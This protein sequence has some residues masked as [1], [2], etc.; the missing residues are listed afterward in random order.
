MPQVLEFPDFSPSGTSVHFITYRK[1]KIRAVRKKKSGRL[2]TLF[3]IHC[4]RVYIDRAVAILPVHPRSAVFRRGATVFFLPSASGQLEEHKTRTQWP[5]A[6]TN[7]PAT[8][9]HSLHCT[10]Q[11]CKVRE[12]RGCFAVCRL[13]H[14]VRRLFTSTQRSLTEMEDTPKGSN[15][16][17][18]S[19]CRR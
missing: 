9:K 18:Y 1:D 12:H 19:P 6:N 2:V 15:L 10:G 13:Q 8:P 4:L 7:Q 17:R 3:Q 16:S 14:E 5:C 11:C